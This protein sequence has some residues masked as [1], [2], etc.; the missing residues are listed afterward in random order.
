MR[1]APYASV[2][3]RS[4]CEDLPPVVGRR[5]HIQLTPEQERIY[6]EVRAET[7]IMIAQGQ[8]ATIKAATLRL[9]KFQQVVG[10]FLRDSNEVDHEIPGGN[11][12][13]ERLSDEVYLSPGKVIVWCQFQWEL[14]RVSAMLRADGWTVWEYHGRVSD[15][16]KKRVRAHFNTDPEVKVLVAQVQ[17]AGRGIDLSGADTI[18]W[19]SHTF[20]AILREQAKER[21]TKMGGGNVRMLD[22][23]GG[24]VDRY[25]LDKV[26]GKVSIGDLVSGRGLQSVLREM[27]NA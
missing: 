18:I 19:Y 20:D 24:E 27:R 9:L 14:D 5:I 6:E 3:L 8:L 2:V 13:L 11:P 15:D 10:G 23:V 26:D 25:V 16:D 12:K 17:S 21:A 7:E 4:D 1:M 22:F